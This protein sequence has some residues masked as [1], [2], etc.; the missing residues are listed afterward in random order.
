MTSVADENKHTVAATASSVAI[1]PAKNLNMNNS[2][3][4]RIMQEY[5]KLEREPCDDF[6]AHPL[7]SDLFEWHFTIRGPPKTE[8]EGGRYHGRILLPSDYPFKPPDLMMLTPSGRYQINTKICLSNTGF[9]P[10]SW[11][12]SWEIR[13]ILVA[14]VSMFPELGKGAIGSLDCGKD[15]RRILAGKS[16]KW[17]CESCGMTNE[18]HLPIESA[19]SSPEKLP[20]EAPSTPSLISAINLTPT[21]A[22]ASSD[23][24]LDDTF[25]AAIEP[26]QPQQETAEEAKLR[27]RERRASSRPAVVSSSPVRTAV[28]P[29]KSSSSNSFVLSL[30]TVVLS[31]A[32]LLLL[33]RRFWP[34]KMSFA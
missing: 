20:E 28:A 9:H 17:R 10:D 1:R 31:L 21:N 34:N 5:K 12:P 22:D 30:L 27:N 26:Q 14:F 25:D 32:V 24:K 4:K 15:E 13:T 23:L 19:P 7:E 11:Q 16:R 2:A 29:K 3:I 33:I 6:V 8:F 18:E